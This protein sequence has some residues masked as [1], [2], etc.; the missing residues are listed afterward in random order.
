MDEFLKNL[1]QVLPPPV[2][3]AL[4]TFVI[5]AWMVREIR[6]Y[7]S[8]GPLFRDRWV[9]SVFLTCLIGT[10]AYYM[11]ASFSGDMKF[12]RT[13]VGVY[14]YPFMNDPHFEV[15][16]EIEAAVASTIDRAKVPNVKIFVSR[17][18]P[19][20]ESEDLYAFATARNAVL[21]VSGVRFTNGDT[22]VKITNPQR[23]SEETLKPKF[24]PAKLA[25]AIQADL[26]DVVGQGGSP[27]PLVA[28]QN[29]PQDGA[30]VAAISTL[31]FQLDDALKR[32]GQLET[33]VHLSGP[34]A[35]QLSASPK[36]A[37]RRLA[38]LVGISK[39]GTGF[40]TSSTEVPSLQYAAD[41]ARGVE[42]V[43]LGR[44]Y[45]RTHVQ[46][47]L[48]ASATKSNIHAAIRRLGELSESKDS[49]LMYFA[50]HSVLE[51]SS[52]GEERGYLL[53]A[54]YAVGAT[55]STAISATE[56][57][58][59]M[60]EVPAGE[61]AIMVD[62]C[63][64]GSFG[65]ADVGTVQTRSLS[66][67][68]NSYSLIP[69]A[70]KLWRAG[71]GKVLVVLSAASRS[72]AALEGPQWN[73]GLFTFHVLNG[74]AGAADLNGDSEIAADELYAFIYPKVVQDSAG[75]QTPVLDAVGTAAMS[76]VAVPPR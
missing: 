34:K 37:V 50:G 35:T 9:Y 15:P 32:L 21:L 57:R 2:V 68:R 31:K 19:P 28:Q 48:D 55:E 14:V 52:S 65:T 12:A 25:D 17:K 53:P 62:G 76:L 75:Q 3:V 39:Y 7:A 11:Y 27:V 10:A 66:V 49:I 42:S 74:L 6:G 13:D 45:E 23:R 70:P 5:G 24:D 26:L 46:T 36:A 51:K 40:G 73:H 8:N 56:L 60:S 16:V 69:P 20:S 4:A 72:Q 58:Q 47:L 43:L 18:Y 63:Y 71:D 33:S 29:Q 30:A 38:L 54:D 44:G 41:D 67:I 1:I 22:W 64:G 61:V 59:W